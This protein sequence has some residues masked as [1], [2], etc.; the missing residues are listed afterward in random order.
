MLIMV[1]WPGLTNGKAR[2]SRIR[3]IAFALTQPPILEIRFVSVTGGDFMPRN[4]FWAAIVVVMVSL[5][6]MRSAEAQTARRNT[7]HC[8]GGK[9]S[10]SSEKVGV[11][12]NGQVRSFKHR[13]GLPDS[14]R[15]VTRRKKPASRLQTAGHLS[16]R[17]VVR[18]ASFPSPAP[19]GRPVSQPAVIRR[20]VAPTPAKPVDPATAGLTPGYP[21][22][23]GSLYPAPQPDVPYQIGGAVITNQA[24][25]P[26]E[27]LYPHS[28]RALYP[29]F[30]YKVAGGWM[31]TPW[32]VWSHDSW[33]LEGTEVKVKYRPRISF[34]TGFSPPVH[35]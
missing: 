18:P 2:N 12:W 13:W 6:P 11:W 8:H 7:P 19:L 4:T 1:G 31:V 27:M 23:H 24:L 28:Y 21:Q 35:R 16:H 34:L 29:P 30:Y 9:P 3:A 17:S 26:H 15:K 33:K 32:G 25:A 14:S 10:S 22:F 20:A 5:L